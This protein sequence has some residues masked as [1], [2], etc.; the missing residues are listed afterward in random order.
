M[1]RLLRCAESALITGAAAFGLLAATACDAKQELLAPQQQ[2][3]VIL[4]GN[5]QSPVAAEGLYNGAVGTSKQGLLGGNATRKRFGS[6][7]D[8]SPMNIGRATR[9]RSATTRINA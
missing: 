2:P 6:S 4:P 7:P 3:G 1:L 9:S 8:C 5:V